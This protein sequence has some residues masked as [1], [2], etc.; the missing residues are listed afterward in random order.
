MSVIDIIR[1]LILYPISL[2]FGYEVVEEDEEFIEELKELKKLKKREEVQME[3][4]VL[5]LLRD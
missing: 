5:V 3:S 2:L 4:Q 1:G